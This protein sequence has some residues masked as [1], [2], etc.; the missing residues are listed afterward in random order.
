MSVFKQAA[1]ELLNRRKPGVKAPRLEESI[2]P[3]SLEDA[4]AIHAEMA[5]IEP[6]T[7][8]KCLFPLAADKIIAAPIFNLQQD[9]D[10]VELFEDKGVARV[11][12][13]VAFVLAK[14]LPAKAE[15]YTE[16]EVLDAVGSAHM[17]LELM[18]SRFEEGAEQSYFE[19]LADCM[20]NQGMFVGPE[21]D[22]AAAAELST[23]KIT[24]TQGD[25]VRELD[26]KHPNERA[27]D[28]L[29]WL[30][31]YMGKRDVSLKAGAA[32]ITGSFKGIVNMAFDVETTIAYEGL[33][34]YQVTFKRA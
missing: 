13:E 29:V 28:G 5:T 27:I 4:F 24:V 17:A 8:W 21:I 7:G 26:G 1:Q 10:V 15:D 34:Q 14:D 16:A 2:R 22:K 3:A 6:V 18:Q 32:I 20:V 12:P 23:V 25:E 31:N 19:S 11:E 9:T 30:V 33:A